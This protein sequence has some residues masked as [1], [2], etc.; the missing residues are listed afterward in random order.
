MSC[1][2]SS[3]LP[4]LGTSTLL[5]WSNAGLVVICT[6]Q[7]VRPSRLCSLRALERPLPNGMRKCD[8]VSRCW[9]R[10]FAQTNVATQ[11][12]KR[13]E[14]RRARPHCCARA[15]GAKRGPPAQARRR[16]VRLVFAAL[17]PP[18]YPKTAP[19]TPS[20]KGH[21][22]KLVVSPHQRLHLASATHPRQCTLRH[23]RQAS[24][25]RRTCNSVPRCRLAKQCNAPH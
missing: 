21:K 8:R 17:R 18:S 11:C 23:P 1:V 14:S 22:C 7:P 13:T 9:R 5:V 10:R 4:K 25:T 12:A 2:C 3:D 6:G 19:P 24:T 16:S 15:S 20:I